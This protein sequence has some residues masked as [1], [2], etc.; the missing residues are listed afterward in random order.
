MEIDKRGT[1]IFYKWIEKYQDREEK[2]SVQ[3]YL[4][5]IRADDAFGIY[6]TIP[7]SDSLLTLFLAGKCIHTVKKRKKKVKRIALLARMKRNLP[8]LVQ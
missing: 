8:C 3:D 6:N 4:T 5:R 7:S 2:S 1:P